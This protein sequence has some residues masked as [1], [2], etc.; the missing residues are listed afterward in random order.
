VKQVAKFRSLTWGFRLVK[1]ANKKNLR[2][3]IWVPA[4]AAIGRYEITF[5]INGKLSKGKMAILFNPYSRF[6]DVSFPDKKL[7]DEYIQGN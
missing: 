3:K 4:N 5:Q 7:L 2:F 1:S 6:D